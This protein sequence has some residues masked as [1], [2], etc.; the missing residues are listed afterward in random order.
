MNIEFSAGKWVSELPNFDGKPLYHKQDDLTQLQAAVL[1][2]DGET[3]ITA[4]RAD[5]EENQILEYS[6]L[7]R[8]FKLHGIAATSLAGTN[9]ISSRFRSKPLP[10]YVRSELS[11]VVKFVDI[12]DLPNKRG[13][14]LS[15]E[16]WIN[17]SHPQMGKLYDMLQSEETVTWRVALGGAVIDMCAYD[18]EGSIKGIL[19][20]LLADEPQDNQ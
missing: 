5:V 19:N 15:D 1:T 11:G 8:Y 10:R 12:P 14:R 2:Q 13:W 7:W 9:R 3:V 4:S 18:F 20:V 17:V 16:T 6:V